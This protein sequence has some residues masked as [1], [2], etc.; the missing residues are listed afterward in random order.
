M[1]TI[2]NADITARIK[3]DNGWWARGKE[4]LDVDQYK[5]R[6]YF[7]AFF[8][9]IWEQRPRR[10]PVVMGPRR[11][12]KT[13]MLR[14][15]LAEWISR[16]KDPRTAIYLPLDTPL[17]TNNPLETLVALAL[18][19]SGLEVMENA[20][21]VFDEV[22]YRMNWEQELKVLHD[23]NP[24]TR[25]VASGSAAAA[26]K[27][28]SQES[29]AG[30]FTDILLPPL[31]FGEFLEFTEREDLAKP[32]PPNLSDH[33]AGITSLNEAFIDYLNFGGFPEAAL[34]QRVRENVVQFVQRD[35][36]D[37]VILR[38]LPSLYGVTDIYELNN[39]FVFLANNTGN[40]LNLENVSKY[41]GISK[42][43]LIKYFTYLEAAFLIRKLQRVDMRSNGFERERAFRIYLASPSLYTA[44]LAPVTAEDTIKVGRLAETAIYGQW[45]HDL[46]LQ[47]N[48]VRLRYVRES[49][50][51]KHPE[52]DFVLLDAATNKPKWALEVKW[53]DR[54]FESPKNELRHLLEYCH[55]NEL[56]SAHVTTKTITSAKMVDGI[57]LNF[58]PTARLA[59][60]IGQNIISGRISELE[61]SSE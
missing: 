4:A 44:L 8:T 28:K 53:T 39:F 58:V 20:L 14:Q 41:I 55:L 26:L 50:Q 60:T 33:P 1:E 54:A 2:N 52:V 27:Q 57:E 40:E 37:K 31:S 61:K 13:V 46:S 9:L 15:A 25:F 47:Q 48:L 36:L 17:Y 12:G 16:G 5:R 29:G 38:D 49:K 7:E 42:P 23:A 30:R 24:K 32:L 21:F 35:I 45:L 19:A 56:M 18:K 34:E 43:K 59:L 10:T 11:V 6:H 51:G 22:Q 3:A